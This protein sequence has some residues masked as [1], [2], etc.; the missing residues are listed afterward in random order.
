MQRKVG[1]PLFS[2]KCLAFGLAA[3]I[4]GQNFLRTVRSSVQSKNPEM[5]RA[6]L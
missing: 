6:S 4:C 5:L 2:G 3:K 1:S